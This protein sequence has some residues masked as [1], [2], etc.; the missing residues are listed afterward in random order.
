MTNKFSSACYLRTRAHT[1]THK[2]TMYSQQ[3]QSI[4]LAIDQELYID[5]VPSLSINVDSLVHFL[6]PDPFFIA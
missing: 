1:H 2:R 4:N 3:N 6:I 5:R